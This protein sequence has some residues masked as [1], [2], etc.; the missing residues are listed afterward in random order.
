MSVRLGRVL[1]G[2]G[3]VA[4]AVMFGGHLTGFRSGLMVFGRF[5]VSLFWH[6]FLP[7]RALL[8]Q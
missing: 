5:L 3:C 4:F 1:C 7:Y 6:N 2:G 8:A